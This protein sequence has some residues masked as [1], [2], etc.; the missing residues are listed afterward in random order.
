MSGRS[1]SAAGIHGGL[2]F[3]KQDGRR[4]LF[5]VENFPP[6]ELGQKFAAIN[7]E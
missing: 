4:L 2:S 6:L 5:P 7:S 1:G 3:S